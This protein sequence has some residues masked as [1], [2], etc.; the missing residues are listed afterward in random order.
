VDFC[1]E[2]FDFGEILRGYLVF[3]EAV[4]EL[5]EMDSYDG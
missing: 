2:L 3:F 4:F 1:D 5:Q